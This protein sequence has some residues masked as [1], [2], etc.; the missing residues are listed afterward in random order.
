[1]NSNT[2]CFVAIFMRTEGPC[3]AVREFDDKFIKVPETITSEQAHRA[4]T[5]Q[6]ILGLNLPLLS[7]TK[8]EIKFLKHHG[9]LGVRAPSCSLITGQNMVTLL[10]SFGKFRIAERLNRAL[11]N[12]EG[13]PTASSGFLMI[14]A[15]D[16]ATL[17]EDRDVKPSRK[18]HKRKAPDLMGP[19]GTPEISIPNKRF[20]SSVWD[21]S[22]EEDGRK[23]LPASEINT[24]G[25][26]S[27][28]VTPPIS[29]DVATDAEF[30]GPISTTR[31]HKY[32][33]HSCDI[34]TN[35]KKDFNK[36]LAT[37]KHRV[38]HS[39]VQQYRVQ[40]QQHL[41]KRLTYSPLGPQF[42]DQNPMLNPGSALAQ[43]PVPNCAATTPNCFTSYPQFFVA[44]PFQFQMVQPVPQMVQ[45]VSPSF[46]QTPNVSSAIMTPQ[47]P[48]AV[49]HP[50]T[51]EPCPIKIDLP[52][53]SAFPSTPQDLVS[54]FF[55]PGVAVPPCTPHES[56]ATVHSVPASPSVFDEAFDRP[57]AEIETEWFFGQ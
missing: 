36:H 45:P 3:L 33:C 7:A 56:I 14:S 8:D 24:P 26:S 43:H 41:A 12:P 19:D 48:V 10:K 38:G 44:S 21:S 47:Q 30:F 52:L 16:L 55:T 6:T 25:C 34:R 32:I 1:M 29:S 2:P 49:E 31:S 9:I 4:V 28:P 50:V 39:R 46:Q 53:K 40:Q 17:P 35:N 5:R 22:D 15:G 51:Q 20:L 54:P 11:N 27:R 57:F 37:N 23:V 18:I 42:V 13:L